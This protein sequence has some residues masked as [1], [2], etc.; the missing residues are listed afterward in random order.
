MKYLKLLLLSFCFIANAHAADVPASD[1]SIKELLTVTQMPKMV[2]AM[3]E[4]IDGM[5]KPSMEQALRGQTLNAKQRKIWDDMNTKLS[6][7]IKQE[8][9]LEAIEA[10][11]INIYGQSLTEQEVRR[12]IDFYRSP[13]GKA[14][15]EKM[16][17]I[18]QATNESLQTTMASMMSKIE[19]VMDDSM[20]Q[21]EAA[22]DK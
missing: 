14:M 17:R 9:S 7:L 20:D 10:M 4:Q 8:M 12:M 19:A 16:P 6:A 13:A 5:V 1:A 21:I 18:L 2:E 15:I 22:E 3:H 11:A